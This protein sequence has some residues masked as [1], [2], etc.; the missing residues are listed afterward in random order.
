MLE[1]LDED[2][3]LRVI[4][5]AAEE[6]KRRGDGRVG[7]ENLLLAVMGCLRRRA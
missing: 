3:R 1:R 7:A 2:A 5:V 6:A 4:S